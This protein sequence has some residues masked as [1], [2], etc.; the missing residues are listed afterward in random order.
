MSWELREYFVITEYL[1]KEHFVPLFTGLTVA[2][3]MT[4]FTKKI[5]DTINGHGF[6]DYSQCVSVT[7]LIMRSGITI[8]N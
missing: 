1:M 8:N 5:L 7:T 2:D 3:D 6:S 4:E